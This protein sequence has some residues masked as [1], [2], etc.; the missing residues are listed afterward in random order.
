MSLTSAIVAGLLTAAAGPTEPV[1]VA[2]PPRVASQKRVVSR[3]VQYYGEVLAVDRGSITLRGSE[4]GRPGDELVIHRFPAGKALAAGKQE[5]NEG[6]NDNYR[7]T[8][9]RV[10][11]RVFIKIYHIG[12][13][14]VCVTVSIMRRPGGVIPPAPWDDAPSPYHEYA[15]AMQ[16]LEEKGIPLPAKY[17]PVAQAAQSAIEARQHKILRDRMQWEEDHIAPRPH[18]LDVRPR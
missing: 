13:E 14:N 16:A 2:P 1:A 6:R 8:D 15:N 7:L 10:G 9:V 5:E 4:M 3:P 18:L 17:D 11:D 12:N